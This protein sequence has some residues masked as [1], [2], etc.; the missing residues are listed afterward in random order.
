MLFFIVCFCFIGVFASFLNAL[1]AIE[2]FD[3]LGLL[4]L[5]IDVSFVETTLAR[6][7]TTRSRRLLDTLHAQLL[8]AARSAGAEADLNSPVALQMKRAALARALHSCRVL[9][10]C[11]AEE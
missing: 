8:Q 3:M 7:A 1:P 10:L 11:F 6:Y 2:C 9:F 5:L 4:Q